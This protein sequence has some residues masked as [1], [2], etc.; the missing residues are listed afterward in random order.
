VRFEHYQLV[1]GPDGHPL[2]LGRGAMGVTYQ[3]VD[4]AL[5]RPVALKVIGERCF[6]DPGA[7]QRFVREA[8]AAARVRD[9]IC[10][11]LRRFWLLAP[12]AAAVSGDES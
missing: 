3:A 8:R 4:L 1:T 10:I 12:S 9:P 7:R 5:R 6:T 2:E 11:N